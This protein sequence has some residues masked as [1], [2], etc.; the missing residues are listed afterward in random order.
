VGDHGWGKSKVL[1]TMRRLGL[2]NDVIFTGFVPPE[3]LPFFYNAADLFVFPSLYEGFGIPPLEAMACGTPVVCSNRGSLPEITGE[4][5][6]MVNPDSPADLAQAMKEVLENKD[7]R[8][9][10]IKKGIRQACRFSWEQTAHATE[11]TYRSAI[12]KLLP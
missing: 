4:A 1:A 10:L 7:Y 6:R 5:A 12:A 2:T 11:D 8:D 9:T 3:D